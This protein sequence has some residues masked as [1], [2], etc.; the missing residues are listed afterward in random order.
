MASGLLYRKQLTI[1]PVPVKFLEPLFQII[2][3][4]Y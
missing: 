4:I 1:S 3:T 2:Y